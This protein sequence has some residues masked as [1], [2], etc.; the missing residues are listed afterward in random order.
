M[1]LSDCQLTA[2]GHIHGASIFAKSVLPYFLHCIASVDDTFVCNTGKVCSNPET[3]F[4]PLLFQY[5]Y[6]LIVFSQLGCGYMRIAF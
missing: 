6:M 1:N 2:I 4:L 5:A 3:F